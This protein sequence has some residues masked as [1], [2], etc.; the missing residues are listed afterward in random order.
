MSWDFPSKAGG[1]P[2]SGEKES[3][4]AERGAQSPVGK[5]GE[6]GLRLASDELL[7]AR[8]GQSGDPLAF[9]LLFERH[10]TA[11]YRVA[12]R[13]LG[14]EADALDAVQEGFIKVLTQWHQFRG[15]SRFK[16][17]LMRVVSRVALDIGRQRQR[18][19]RCE[20][21]SRQADLQSSMHSP[22]E[23]RLD[24][25]ELRQQVQTALASLP[26]LQRQALVLY[27]DGGLTYRE[28]ADVQG[29]SLGTVMSR[30][31]HARRKLRA[32]LARQVPDP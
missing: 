31:F 6:E 2:M 28:I 27:V 12:W 17:W 7:L 22:R 4:P 5:A 18:H 21:W 10:R 15:Q 32:L 11:A 25:E 19:N 8:W 3:L 26:A 23:E 1:E 14:N 13:L 30:L 24:G 16:T 9:A 20:S 29:V